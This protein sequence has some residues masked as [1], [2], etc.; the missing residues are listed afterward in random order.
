MSEINNIQVDDARG[1]DV[2]IPEYNLVEYSNTFSKAS[3]GLWQ[4]YRYEPALDNINNTIDFPA[5]NNNSIS[6]KF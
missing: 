5:D 6:L 1:I 3:G 2:V 4:Y